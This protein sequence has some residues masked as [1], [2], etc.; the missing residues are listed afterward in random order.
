MCSLDDSRSLHV[1]DSS[2][3]GDG[4]L[5]SSSLKYCMLAHV[6]TVLLRDPRKV[7]E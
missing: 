3:A 7:W 6:R 4:R 2:I 1:P 5:R